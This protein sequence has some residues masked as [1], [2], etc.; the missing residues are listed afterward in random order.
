MQ[1][2]RGRVLFAFRPILHASLFVAS[3]GI[4][5]ARDK[6]AGKTIHTKGRRVWCC[7]DEVAVRAAETRCGA[8]S[9]GRSVRNSASPGKHVRRTWRWRRFV[10]LR[11]PTI[12]LQVR[13]SARR[14][15]VLCAR[16]ATL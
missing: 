12:I 8:T 2:E 1:V 3:H 4:V 6:R 11:L 9:S 16:E 14:Q 5:N 15:I 7:H 13:E 10:S